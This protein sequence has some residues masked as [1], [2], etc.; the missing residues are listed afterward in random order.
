MKKILIIAMLGVLTTLSACKKDEAAPSEV[1]VQLGKLSDTWVLSSAVKDETEMSGYEDFT[2]TLS[3]STAATTFTYAAIGRPALSPW[4]A[5][6]TWVFGSTVSSQLIRDSE[7]ADEVLMN[8][9]VTETSLEIEFNFSG[10]GY[11]NNGRV[12]SPEGHWIFTFSK[13]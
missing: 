7:T 10:E 13:Q 3:G 12:A 4:P 1:S 9:T 8:Y 5:G 6:G 11:T 2:L